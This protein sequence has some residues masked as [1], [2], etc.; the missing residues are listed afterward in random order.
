MLSPFFALAAQSPS[1]QGTF[2]RAVAAHLVVLAAA[3]LTLAYR[4]PGS[5]PAFLGHLLLVLGIVEGATLVGWRLTQIPKSQALE[6]LLVSPIRPRRVFLA[7]AAVGLALLALV[8]LSGLP[9]LLILGVVGHLHPLDAV[10]LVLMP[11]TWGAL[12]GLGLTAWAYEPKRFRRWGERGVMALILLYLVVGVLAG[13][14]LR[15]WLEFLPLEGQAAFLHVFVGFHTHNP[16]GVV[17]HWMESPIRHAWPRALGLEACALAAIVLLLARAAVR[18]QGHFHE[19]HYEPVRDVRA[20]KRLAVGDRPLSWWAVKRVTEYSGRINLWLAGGFCLLYALYLLAGDQWPAWVGRRVFAMCDVA[21]GPAGLGAALVV[22]AAV[23]AAFQ[24]GLWDSSNQD[25]CRRLELLLLTHLQPRDY[26]HAAA[27]AAWR[28]GR[29]YFALAVL[30]WAAA[31][32][33]GRF[34]V[35][36]ALTAV[37]AAALLW[38]L[39]FA[40]GFRAFARGAQAN[41]LGMLLTVGQPLGAFALARLG[42]PVAAGWLPPGMVYRAGA[43]AGGLA[44]LLGPALAAALCLVVARHSLATC[45]T[46]LRR[47]YDAH[48]GSK[49]MS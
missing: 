31:L 30:L 42:W 11:W 33:G 25:R 19:R 48:H 9:L 26:W 20:E 6:F 40:L 15:R 2:R 28:R 46:T 37:A 41:G 23:P 3:V 39:Y 47:W 18:L 13:E 4:S 22:L 45:D 12:T 21:A 16:F 49:V 5:S 35:A 43:G 34:S 27:A 1:R 44:W 14:H 7:E 8:S 10:F 38:G 17:Q 36:Q 32:V 29:G 24:Y